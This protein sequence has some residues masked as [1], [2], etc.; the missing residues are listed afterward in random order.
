MSLR[1]PVTTRSIPVQDI[2]PA[3]LRQLWQIRHDHFPVDRGRSEERDFEDFAAYF[4]RERRTVNIF[5]R[6]R[7]P[8]GFFVNSWDLHEAEGRRAILISIEFTYML[9]EYRGHPAFLLAGFRMYLRLRLGHPLTPMFY[10]GYVFPNSFA[11]VNESFG[12]AFTLQEDP[13]PFERA[14]LLAYARE[15]GGAK[16][17][18][19]RRVA[20]YQNRP[21]EHT[22][23]R[24]SGE[25][26]RHYQ[27]YERL[28]PTW[29][30]GDAIV[31]LAPA[32][33]RAFASVMRRVTRRL[34]REVV[35]QRFA[36]QTAPPAA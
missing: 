11:F 23:A 29:R 31:L 6:G 30:D 17:D 34:A 36:R 5:F 33:G 7:D 10:V 15:A 4:Q 28:V 16:W 26:A 27:R 24:R 22:S 13:P 3:L 9:P 12:R 20:H 35:P 1:R 14:L 32:D 21:P 2:E 19:D 25:L 8:V 18:E